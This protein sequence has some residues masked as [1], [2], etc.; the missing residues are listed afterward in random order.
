MRTVS[1]VARGSRRKQR[2]VIAS[3]TT[4]AANAKKYGN[5]IFGE[6]SPV[7]WPKLVQNLLQRKILSAQ[8]IALAGLPFFQ[9]PRH[10][11]ARTRLTSTRFNPVST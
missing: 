8:N 10:A 1:I 9:A 11:R 2:P 4:P 5:L 7:I 6:G 3:S